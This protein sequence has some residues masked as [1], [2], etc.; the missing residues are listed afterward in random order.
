MKVIELNRIDDGTYQV[1]VEDHYCGQLFRKS[2]ILM[3]EAD[4]DHFSTLKD[5]D[6]FLSK[7]VNAKFYDT[8][9]S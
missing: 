8:P 7:L 5:M 2:K 9:A 4:Q 3:A 1:V 6:T